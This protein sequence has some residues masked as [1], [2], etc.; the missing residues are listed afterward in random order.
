MKKKVLSFA[1]ALALCLGLTV[2]A[3]AEPYI[4]K[5]DKCEYE[6]STKPIGRTFAS[7]YIIEAETWEES[8][9]PVEFTVYIVPDNTTLTCKTHPEAAMTFEICAFEEDLWASDF[10]TDEGETFIIKPTFDEY[11][12]VY[13]Y[14]RTQKGPML[15]D[16]DPYDR[17]VCVMAESAAKAKGLKPPSDKEAPVEETPANPFTDVA[18]TSPFYNAIL[19]AVEQ[20]ITKGKTENT[21]GPG[22]TCTISHI[23]TFLWRANGRPGDNGDERASVT[24]WA[25]SLDIDTDSLSTPCTRSAAVT[26]MWKAAGSPEV[27][28]DKAFTDVSA[29]AEFASAVAWAVESGVTSGTGDGTTFSPDTTCTRGQIVTFLHRAS[30]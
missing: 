10:W 29:D 12:H 23:L 5:S 26:F 14:I 7:F 20:N 13:Y 27:S 9:E 2:P 17:G 6:L 18:E 28:T 1:L 4:I 22:D 30:K 21:F 8:E 15:S 11:G 19:W 25:Q 24:A 3:A 16:L